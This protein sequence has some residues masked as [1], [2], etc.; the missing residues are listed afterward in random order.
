MSAAFRDIRERL[1]RSGRLEAMC[2]PPPSLL[3]HAGRAESERRRTGAYRRR[4]RWHN[5]GGVATVAMRTWSSVQWGAVLFLA[6]IDG[7]GAVQCA[8][9]TSKRHYFGAELRMSDRVV[10]LLCIEIV[11]QLVAMQLLFGD[12]A[13]VWPLCAF[14]VGVSVAMMRLVP[15][16]LRR[17]F[18]ALAFLAASAAMRGA[19]DWRGREWFPIVVCAKYFLSH[20]PHV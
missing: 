15:T 18:G 11:V 17:P 5:G 12:V 7:S 2:A 9:A 10:V 8:S 3:D 20:F 19:S 6:L 13:H 14:F 16:E 4:P 1:Q